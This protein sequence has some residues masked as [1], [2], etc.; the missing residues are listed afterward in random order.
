MT[1]SVTDKRIVAHSPQ[2]LSRQGDR[3]DAR[4]REA[5][6]NRYG[7]D[8]DALDE[9]GNLIASQVDVTAD[10]HL[11][12]VLGS[13]SNKDRVHEALK[14]QV[15][16]STE[17]FQKVGDMDEKEIHSQI[18]PL[19]FTAGEVT[20]GARC[21]GSE[22]QGATTQGKNAQ[23]GE[24]RKVHG[25]YGILLTGSLCRFCIWGSYHKWDHGCYF[26]GQQKEKKRTMKR[27]R[28]RG[29]G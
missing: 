26:V 14:Q 29:P 4:E 9:E 10:T 20:V 1:C 16:T 15:R 28:Q 27:E 11:N 2:M 23:R 7:F 18:C 3:D 22:R 5:L 24:A 8:T 25:M 13:N 19:S 6:L 12:Q 17:A 21:Q